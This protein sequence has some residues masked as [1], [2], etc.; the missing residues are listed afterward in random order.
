MSRAEAIAERGGDV[1]ETFEQ[2]AREQRKR[3]ELGL[4]LGSAAAPSQP[5]AINPA[6]NQQQSQTSADTEDNNEHTQ[7]NNNAEKDRAE[8]NG[9]E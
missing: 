1:D 3:E 6:E 8:A 2:L 5:P 4:K 7:D 9:G